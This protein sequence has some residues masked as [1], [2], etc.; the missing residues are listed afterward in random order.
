MARRTSG[1]TGWRA[2]ICLVV[3]LCAARA[4]AEIPPVA[5]GFPN[6]PQTPGAI[7]SGLNAPQQGRTA[8]IA[9]QDGILFTVPEIPSSQP[10]ADFQ[11]RTWD[12]RNPRQPIEL[13][14]WGVTP[15]PV[16]AHGYFHSGPYLVLGANWPPGG[17]WSFRVSPQRV[18]TRTAFPELTCA[19]VR[20][21]L[22]GPWYINDTYWSYNAVGGD[23]EI[24]FDWQLLARWDHLG[25]TG[26][27]GHPFLLGDL[28]IFASDQSRTGVATYDVSDPRHP[29]LLDVLTTGGP[30]GYFPELWGGDGKLYIVFPYNTEGN[31]FRV[32][33]VT[34]PADLRFVTDR[35]LPGAASMYIQFQDEFA[36]MGDHKVDMRRFESVLH[37]DAANVARPNQPG[38]VG[39]DTSQF[40]LPLGNLLV[41]GG[42]GEDE[43]MA[44]WAHQAEPD[45]RGPSVG[46]HI[47]Q[48]GRTNYP[49]GA[50]ISLLIHETLATA[51]IVNGESF[52]VRP[53][54]GAPLPGRLTFSFDDVL[55]FQPD[56]P[57]AP[58]TT[59]E[60]VIPA[61]GIKDVAG[62][63]IAGYAFTF[64]TGATVAGNAPPEVT[65]F[66]PSAYPAAPGAAVTLTAEATDADGDPL[67]YRFDFGDGTPKTAWS[68]VRSA[69]T[70]YAAPGHYRATVQV[71]DPSGALASE[72]TL[73]TVL[74]PPAGPR[75]AHSGP[76]ACDA[77]RRLIWSVNPDADT[78]TAVDADTLAV[79]V[80]VPACA[81]PR[82]VAVAAGGTVWVTCHDDDRVV[83]L[84]QSG[85]RLAT[86]STGY[87][88]APA[89]LAAAPDG[90]TLY[91]ALQGAGALLRVDAA[92]RQ[93]T[94]RLP[95]GPRPRAVA[96]SADGARV[97]VTRFLSATDRAEVWDVNAASFT[98]TRTL[99]IPKFGGDANRDTTAAGRGVANHLAAIAIAPDGRSAWVAA[100]KPN[101][102]RGLLVAADLDQ[103]NTVR[104]VVVQLDLVSNTVARAVDID[105]S[106]SA[107]ALAFAPHGDYLL[108]AL[109][110]NNELLVLDTLALDDAAGLGGFVAR[111][112]VGRA[113]QGVCV[114]PSTG[115][116]VVGNLL[117]HD[118]TVL[119][120]ATLFRDGVL[121]VASEAVTTVAE[122][123]L[124][125]AVLAGKQLFY[126]ASDPRMSAEGYLSCATCHLDGGHDGRTWDFT[127]R[128]EGLRNTTTL[129]GRGGLAHGNVHWSANFDE[130]QDF[131]HDIRGAFGGR[132]FLSDADF[133]AAA[134]PLGPPKAGRSAE[135]DALAAYVA[136]L[137]A[138]S[139]PRSPFRNPDGSMTAEALAGEALFA[140]LGCADCHAG[141][142]FTDSTA[143][144]ATLHDVGTL[145]STSGQR[146]GA[147]LAGI[148]TPTLLGV[149]DTA[150]YFHDGSAATLDDVFRVIGGRVIQ[151]ETGQVANG[152]Q[153]VTD[154]VEYNNDDTVRGRRYVAFG[155][156][157]ARVTFT[158]VDGGPGGNGAI[159]VRYSAGYNVATLTLT[160]NGVAR[161]ASLPL[162]GNDP[163]WRHVNWG[164]VRFDD[165]PLNAGTNNTVVLSTPS[166]FPNISIDELVVGTAAQRIAAQPHRQVL[167]LAT[168]DRAAL[169]AYLRQ[170]DGAPAEGPAE[171]PTDT[172]TA[173]A[174]ATPT[175]PSATAT[176]T[177]LPARHLVGGQVRHAGSDAA[178]AGVTL[179]L[180]GALDDEQTSGAGG[181]YV[182]RD[183][184]SG[185]Y[186]ITARRAG[187]T[188]AVTHADALAAL[189]ASVGLQ[190]PAGLQA[191]VCDV[192][193]DG[194]VTALDAARILQRLAGRLDRFAVSTACD[195]DW[196]FTPAPGIAGG[197][198]VIHSGQCTP[199]VITIPALSAPIAAADFLAAAIG[200]CNLAE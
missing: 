9:Y 59:Y 23:A 66:A 174:T 65:A 180:G 67:E 103:D 126:D 179:V 115:R 10:G 40:L 135:L 32:V 125:P 86:L 30:G 72:S 145:R 123:P 14:R 71:R 58:N 163:G 104:N 112:A 150:P 146:L 50:P 107:A 195:S 127:G 49:R 159:E 82:G 99:A 194:R 161:T 172:P 160:V 18:V 73:V 64:A 182:F 178:L 170:L 169:V 43:G 122:E 31:G 33:D 91:V 192:T 41:T 167:A 102:E 149:W 90:A 108:V 187:A 89:G 8:I 25:T 130:I 56:A 26:V 155:N 101:S 139:V 134:T 16:N 44:I 42:V 53:L 119:D 4:A 12:I 136:S 185:A 1:Q 76:V 15:M 188:A 96:V 22:F 27:I 131:E 35:A 152:A 29:V 197:V 3:W 109:Q 48:A 69:G 17:E 151:A 156:Q 137:D 173:A 166:Q 132:G 144:A 164:R 153:V 184:P 128:G 93:P 143:P 88:S 45:T 51:T 84:D 175:L 81:D 11:V 52:I 63:G 36:F 140:G 200:D 133:A 154:W 116:T 2:G 106:D 97:L 98:L 21:C 61:G 165:V 77:A 129:H 120:T 147:A 193:G 111:L 87:G 198:P 85:A 148:D 38:Q 138:A 113:P 47:P 34:D 124:A 92:T 60:V 117:S 121:S 28:L 105:N 20:G 74:T 19:G 118:V 158:G 199:G 37:L 55:T 162:L 190:V 79:R 114:D 181:A 54:G 157:H 177:S 78:V 5:N 83:V 191:L 189:A 186:T 13:A 176:P 142:T 100:N 7:L 57:L 39:I 95:L 94:G 24:W 75:P 68:S 80:E 62:N 196:L 46:F 168:A 70:T 6:V 141:A 183:L 171:T 110:G